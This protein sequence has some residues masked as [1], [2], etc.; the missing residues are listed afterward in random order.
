MERKIMM[1]A[2][3]LV[4]ITSPVAGVVYKDCQLATILLNQGIASSLINNCKWNIFLFICLFIH[5]F[6]VY[7]TT[8]LLAQTI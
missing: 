3:A 7:L 5:L 6:I 1:M 8:L 2:L 4:A